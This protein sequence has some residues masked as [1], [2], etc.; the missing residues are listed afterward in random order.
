M[1]FVKGNKFA[2]GRP[3]GSKNKEDLNSLR[4]LLQESFHSN[5]LLIK[6]TINEMLKSFDHQVTELNKRIAES[7]P[8][9]KEYTANLGY[10]ARVKSNLLEEFKWL[11]QLKASLEPKEVKAEHTGIGPRTL[12]VIHNYVPNADGTRNESTNKAEPE[13][14][15]RMEQ[16]V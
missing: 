4:I 6:N 5:R 3:K 8:D 12:T 10:Y 2:K 15:P 16:A 11:M 14:E 9:D 7:K 13:A 1:G